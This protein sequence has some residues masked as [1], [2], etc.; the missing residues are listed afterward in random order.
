MNRKTN[1]HE[2]SVENAATSTSFYDAVDL[3]DSE[4]VSFLLCLES[5]MAMQVRNYGNVRR[6]LQM[7]DSD[8]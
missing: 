3:H 1:L 2:L 6:R 4:S 5:S 8:D 7:W